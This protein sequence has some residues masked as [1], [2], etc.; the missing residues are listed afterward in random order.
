MI[1]YDADAMSREQQ[2]R[3][4]AME[5]VELYLDENSNGQVD[6]GDTLLAFL[7][8]SKEPNS[9]Y[10]PEKGKDGQMHQ[11][12]VKFN[13]IK[14]PRKIMLSLADDPNLRYDLKAS[15]MTTSTT[16]RRWKNT[17]LR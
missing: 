8:G 10:A 16:L 4:S 13:Y 14:V 6:A 11:K 7:D 9:Y 3:I 15:F 17:P 12:L 1:Y 5:S 2:V